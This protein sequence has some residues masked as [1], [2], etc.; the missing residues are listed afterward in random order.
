MWASRLVEHW[1]QLL[2]SLQALDVGIA[3]SGW[4]IKVRVGNG[5]DKDSSAFTQTLL[6]IQVFNSACIAV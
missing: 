3:T 1:P 2:M 4:T 5:I 6:C